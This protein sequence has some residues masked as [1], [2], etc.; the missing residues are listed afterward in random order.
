MAALALRKL[1]ALQRLGLAV[2]FLGLVLVLYSYVVRCPPVELDDGCDA[3]YS[4]HLFDAGAACVLLFLCV[5]QFSLVPARPFYD[6]FPW[7]KGR[8]G[9]HSKQRAAAR[10]DT[11]GGTYAAHAASVV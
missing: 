5:P 2:L 3:A 11:E 9:P 4:W 6:Q 7:L 10:K 8:L 1:D